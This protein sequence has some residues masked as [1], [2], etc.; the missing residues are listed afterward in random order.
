MYVLLCFTF[1][2]GFYFL[3]NN[4]QELACKGE[5]IFLLNGFYNIIT[6]SKS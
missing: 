5:M 3:D 2:S 6:G 1:S 4:F